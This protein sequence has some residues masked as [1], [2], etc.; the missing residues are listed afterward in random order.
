[1]YFLIIKSHRVLRGKIQDEVVIMYSFTW[2]KDFGHSLLNYE[3]TH[4]IALVLICSSIILLVK[5][6]TLILKKSDVETTP[7][8]FIYYH[9]NNGCVHLYF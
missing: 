4:W 5:K 9:L 8:C 2:E 3:Q 1:M 7:Y 6:I